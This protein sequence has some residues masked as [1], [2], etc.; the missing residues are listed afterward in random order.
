[1]SQLDRIYGHLTR[2]P[3]TPL[4]ALNKYG[5]FRLAARCA[6]LRERGHKVVTEIIQR[7]GKRFARYRLAH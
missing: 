3:I 7:K 2:G 4:Q 1:M 6:E 5:V